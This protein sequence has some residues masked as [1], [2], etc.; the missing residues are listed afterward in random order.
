MKTHFERVCSLR[1]YREV[2][3]QKYI[4]EYTMVFSGILFGLS[5]LIFLGASI[6]GF[7]TWFDSRSPWLQL[8]LIFVPMSVF[9]WW[10]LIKMIKA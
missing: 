6:P 4:R 1:E 5:V 2:Q 3:R 9:G 7:Y 8:F 10:R